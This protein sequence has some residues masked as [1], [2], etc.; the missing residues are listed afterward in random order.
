MILRDYQTEAIEATRHKIVFEKKKRIIIHSGTGTG[1]TVIGSEI[2]KSAVARGTGVLWLAHRKE[3]IN[4][5]YNKLLENGIESNVIMASDPR[6]KPWL[7]VSIASVPTLVKRKI[8]PRADLIIVDECHRAPADSY[9]KILECYPDAVVLGL[10][11]T[12]CRANNSKG[13]GDMFE[14]MVSCPSVGDMM[15]RINPETG[16][17]YLVPVTV[18]EP[19]IPKTKKIKVGASGD[20]ETTA[21]SQIYS[22]PT[23]VGSI[24]DNWLKYGAGRRTIL[25][26]AGIE[27]SKGFVGKFKEKGVRAEHL[28]GT[29]DPELRDAILRRLETHE[30]EIVSNV[31]VLT[32]GF[33]SPPTSCIILARPTKSV[34]LFLQMCGRALRPYKGKSDCLI[35]DHAGCHFEH[36]DVDEDRE[37]DLNAGVKRKV[38][39][40]DADTSPGIVTCRRCARRFRY[41][42]KKCPSCGHENPVKSRTVRVVEGEM[43][44]REKGDE[45]EKRK[46]PAQLRNEKKLKSRYIELFKIATTTKKRDGT[47]YKPGY[48]SIQ[49][50]AETNWWPRKEWKE[51]AQRMI[52]AGVV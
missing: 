31:G 23:I 50:H 52:T 1:K 20:Y 38:I 9:Q 4:Q 10:T 42:P 5:G 24:V 33:D 18:Y 17:P 2:T 21:L 22:N 45:T 51:E 48:A 13:L 11:A 37:W 28:D 29:T 14:D 7:T 43:R 15:R 47:P 36:G 25:F 41:G 27:D 19:Y 12:P 35:L 44:K 26:A 32:E 3:L 30:T 46:S 39:A 34:G 49:F 16:T 6:R 40:D 8:K